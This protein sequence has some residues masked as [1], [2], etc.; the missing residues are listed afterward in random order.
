MIGLILLIL[1]P[2]YIYRN[3]KQNGHNAILW[4]VITIAI[5][6]FGQL[7][8]PLM[9]GITIGIVMAMNGATE[10]EIE[11]SITPYTF[12][13][14]IASIVVT[15]F[16]YFFVANKINKVKDDEVYQKPPAPNEFF[17][18]NNS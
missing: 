3:A 1:A 5:G 2:I 7:F 14:N 11:N 17:D 16:G 10:T 12:I 15:A 18:N 4:T 8:L 6:L 9:I 13:I